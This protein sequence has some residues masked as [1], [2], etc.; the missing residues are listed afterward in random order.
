MNDTSAPTLVKWPFLIGD[1]LLLAVAAGVV[2]QQI[3]PLSFASALLVVGC[4]ALGAWLGVTPFLVEFRAQVKFAEAC[5]LSSAIDQIKHLQT[6][7]EQI[8]GATAQ[9]QTVQELSAKSVSA[10]KEIGERMA[11]EAKGFAEF[12]QKAND[13]EKG[14]LRLEVEK[15]RRGEGEWLQ[16]MVRL[17]DHVHALYQAGARSK[18]PGIADQLGQFQHT[19]REIVRRL[20]VVPF[21]AKEDETFD[22]QKHQ[23]LEDGSTLPA[24][25]RISDT[26][27]TGYHFQGRMVRRAVVKVKSAEA[28]AKAAATSQPAESQLS[29]V[30]ELPAPEK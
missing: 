27:A 8:S 17:L 16:A 25:A 18:H 23:H 6:V 22:A 14:H 10:A 19:C 9:W 24:K 4:V 2:Y 26:V 15:L 13:T 5:Q 3:P 11:A 1:L 12:M 30:D 21:E 7:G 20:G 28:E 29:L